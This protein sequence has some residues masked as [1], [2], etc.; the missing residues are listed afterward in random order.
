MQRRRLND[1]EMT[2]RASRRL[3]C[4]PSPNLIP[5]GLN[6]INGNKDTQRQHLRAGT[7]GNYPIPLGVNTTEGFGG[8]GMSLFR[9]L[10]LF[11]ISLLAVTGLAQDG[12]SSAAASRARYLG[13]LG[14]IPS[15]R[16]IAVE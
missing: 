16:E 7:C 9:T 11:V 6:P 10:F 8:L 14:I 3:F 12:V 1:K 2:V 15:S 13:E 4:N 5:R